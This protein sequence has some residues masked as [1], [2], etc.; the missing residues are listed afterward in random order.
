MAT[1]VG[2]WVGLRGACVRTLMADVVSSNYSPITAAPK[3]PT[4]RIPG[5]ITTEM[6]LL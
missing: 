3:M 1:R 4:G 5:A 2:Q 6:L